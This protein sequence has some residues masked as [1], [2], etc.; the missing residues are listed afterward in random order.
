MDHS[1]KKTACRIG[2][3]PHVAGAVLLLLFALSGSAIAQNGAVR[4]HQIK[5]AFLLNFLQFIQW[6]PESFATPT[7]PI[8]V[9]IL[10]EDELAPALQRTLTGEMVGDRKVLVRQSRSLE[11]LKNSHVLFVGN[12]ERGRLDAI[13]TELGDAPVLTVSDIPAFTSRGIIG[14]YIE[15][16]KVRFEINAA[17]AQLRNIKVHSQLL[18]RARV[19]GPRPGRGRL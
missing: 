8:I 17:A 12:S 5:A 9:G 11:E 6:P 19:V 2:R 18:A 16:N 13:F 15:N 7:S 1:T 10:G 14:F 4:E 3:P